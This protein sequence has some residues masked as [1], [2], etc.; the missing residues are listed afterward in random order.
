MYVSLLRGMTASVDS[1]SSTVSPIPAGRHRPWD[2]LDAHCLSMRENLG[3]EWVCVPKQYPNVAKIPPLFKCIRSMT[4]V[5]PM[6]CHWLTY[7]VPFQYQPSRALLTS[8]SDVLGRDGSKLLF[9]NEIRGFVSMRY[10]SHLPA[11][12]YSPLR[13][14]LHPCTLAPLR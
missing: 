7:L 13:Q 4:A 1:L 11:I 12:S 14:A 6:E 3:C 10:L 9:T 8:P 5:R 2:V